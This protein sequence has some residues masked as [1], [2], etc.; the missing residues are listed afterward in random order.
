MHNP[1]AYQPPPLR[2]CHLFARASLYILF[3]AALGQGIYLEALYFP[4]LRFTEYGFTELTQTTLLVVTSALLPYTRQWLKVLPGITLLMLAFI[5]SSLIRGQNHFL[6]TLVAP[7]VWKVLVTLVIAPIV[8]RVIRDRHGFSKEFSQ[9]ANSFSFGIFAAGVLTTYV[10]SRLYGRSKL[11]EAILQDNYVRT[12][13]D[14]AEESIELL[15]YALILIAVIEM[16][17]LAKHWARQRN[18]N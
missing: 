1:A 11:W 2:F 5:V 13:K 8:Y 15:G 7:H 3:I 9:Y 18:L 16:L 17:I 14:A 4:A 12:F 6:D 10:F